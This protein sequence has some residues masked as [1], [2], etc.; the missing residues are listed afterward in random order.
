[1]TSLT[2][3][4]LS[5]TSIAPQ[6]L[7][8]I[9]DIVSLREFSILSCDMKEMTRGQI[10]KYTTAFRSKLECF[11]FMICNS[12]HWISPK[13][14]KCFGFLPLITDLEDL[15]TDSWNLFKAMMTS[16]KSP[17]P[18]R[19]LE[20]GDAR[21]TWKMDIFEFLYRLPTL[22]SL[23]LDSFDPEDFLSETMSRASSDFLFLSRMTN[24][25]HLTCPPQMV[26][27]LKGPH[28]LSHLAFF[29][30][31]VR[32]SDDLLRLLR[33]VAQLDSWF[34]IDHYASISELQIP[35]I[36]LVQMNL[37]PAG[38]FLTELRRLAIDGSTQLN[39]SIAPDDE[40]LKKKIWESLHLFATPS[41]KELHFTDF[42]QRYSFATTRLLFGA[43]IGHFPELARLIFMNRNGYNVE[44]TKDS[45]SGEWV[46][47][48]HPY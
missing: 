41:V 31:N 20:L 46:L 3:V 11:R 25:R 2:N 5:N 18:L 8:S 29:T 12:D 47:E 24:L 38:I 43:S 22:T 28:N 21:V 27:R 23:S 33:S 9:R 10:E 1:M 32:S 6:L 15:R 34:R 39:S 17:P 45:A 13:R 30:H 48:I 19:I 16:S 35:L 42:P 37:A 4:V 36:F 14:D 44:C 40:W 26:P 7:G